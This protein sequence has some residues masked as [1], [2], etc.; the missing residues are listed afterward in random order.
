MTLYTVILEQTNVMG[1]VMEVEAES[2]QQAGHLALAEALTE[3]HF[4]SWTEVSESGVEVVSAT[5]HRTG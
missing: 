5:K 2:L 3:A 1:C 4:D